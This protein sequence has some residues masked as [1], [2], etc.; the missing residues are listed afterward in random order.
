MCIGAL[1][2]VYP[3]REELVSE[4]RELLDALREGSNRSLELIDHHFDDAIR[5]LRTTP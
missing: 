1:E 5:R 2:A 4:H 3:H